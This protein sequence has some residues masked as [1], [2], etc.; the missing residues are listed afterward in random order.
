MVN[1]EYILKFL[2]QNKHKIQN[3]YKVNKI[4]LFGSYARDEATEN[5]DIDI[6]VDMVPSFDNFFDLKYFLEDEFK[7]KV[8]LG[9]EKNLRL[10]IKNKIQEDLIYV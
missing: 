7:T 3:D 1:K 10:Y 2:K 6:L 8:D 5:S 9:K 4:A